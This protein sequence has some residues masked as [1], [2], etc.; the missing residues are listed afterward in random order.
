M[1]HCA[2]ILFYIISDTVSYMTQPP[3]DPP[4]KGTCSATPHIGL[5]IPQ[6]HSIRY[7]QTRGWLASCCRAF[8]LIN[9]FVND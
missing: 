9:E 7:W 1:S 6:S 2:I 3:P 8:L 5:F 4:Q